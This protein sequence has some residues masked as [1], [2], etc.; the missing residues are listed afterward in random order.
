MQSVPVVRL[1]FVSVKREAFQP[2]GRRYS[3]ANDV[4][5]HGSTAALG[6]HGNGF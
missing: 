5:R 1:I 2:F 3:V 6:V 4:A